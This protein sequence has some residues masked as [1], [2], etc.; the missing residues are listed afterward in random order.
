MWVI[1]C[2]ENFYHTVI[3][4]TRKSD[5]IKKIPL[6]KIEDC[7]KRLIEKCKD[8]QLFQLYANDFFIR[9]LQNM[10]LD[11]KLLV[12]MSN[13]ILGHYKLEL[14]RIDDLKYTKLNS[15]IVKPKRTNYI[16]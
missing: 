10:P 3:P 12:S 15:Y 11:T 13:K 8:K 16:M 2:S 7:K 4:T 5:I 9:L 6:E 14:Y 1:Y